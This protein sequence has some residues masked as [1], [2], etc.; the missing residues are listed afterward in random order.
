[1]TLLAYSSRTLLLR[2][3]GRESEHGFSEIK[4][5]Y[6][7]FFDSAPRRLGELG[8][9][10]TF[11]FFFSLVIVLWCR[12]YSEGSGALPGVNPATFYPCQWRRS[13][14]CFGLDRHTWPTPHKALVRSRCF[15]SEGMG[16]GVGE[17]RGPAPLDSGW[18][19]LTFCLSL[20]CRGM[21]G[22][23]GGLGGWGEEGGQW[24]WQDE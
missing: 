24:W 16:V 6:L 3:S 23:V 19:G 18:P 9:L 21:P 10:L 17:G 7:L 4:V 15:E 8:H 2:C 12:V 20:R 5:T 14:G 11:D 22:W 1:M 13:T